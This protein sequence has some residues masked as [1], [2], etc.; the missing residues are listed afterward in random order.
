MVYDVGAHRG[1]YTVPLLCAGCTVV[2][3]E[4]NE[5]EVERLQRNVAANTVEQEEKLIINHIGLSDKS[6]RK[7]LYVSHPFTGRSS[8]SR[9]A[10]V[11]EHKTHSVADRQKVTLEPLDSVVAEQQLPPPDYL[12]VDVEGHGLQVLQGARETLLAHEP[13]VYLELHGEGE[14]TPSTDTVV[15]FLEEVGYTV[16]SIVDRPPA[17]VCTT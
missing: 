5:K 17:L 12:K 15:Q 3:F 1:F 14:G 4:P 11:S 10:A 13:K 9:V 16:S 2:A 8:L 7:H 6:A